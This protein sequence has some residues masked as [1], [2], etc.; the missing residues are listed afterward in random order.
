MKAIRLSAV[1]A[2]VSALAA[3]MG[4]T[5][6]QAGAAQAAPLITFSS[7]SVVDPVHAYGEPDV[8][9]APDG[10]YTTAARGGPAP[11]GASGSGRSTAA[12]RIARST[13]RPS[14]RQHS[15]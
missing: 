9:V 12:P 11:S 15:P 6:A 10:T 3:W 7:P 13:R 1:V 4:G 2:L 5:G 8:R 14:R